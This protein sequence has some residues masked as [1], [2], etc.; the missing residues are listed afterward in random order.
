MF[1]EI[2]CKLEI[3][4]LTNVSRDQIYQTTSLDNKFDRFTI[5]PEGRLLYTEYQVMSPQEDRWIIDCRA[6][7]YT[8][9]LI[10][11]TILHNIKTDHIIRALAIVNNG[12]LINHYLNRKIQLI[13]YRPID[14][15]D[16][17]NMHKERLAR[18]K[19]QDQE[20]SKITYKLKTFFSKL[21]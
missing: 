4:E 18:Q 15:T 1:D 20:R 14:N 8:G 19:L 2:I 12:Q 7:Q 13:E 5:T 3:P 17:T 11:S 6:H 10:F 16:R 21:K 9:E